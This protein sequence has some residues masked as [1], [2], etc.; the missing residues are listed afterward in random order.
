M[1]KVS[2]SK[3]KIE[4]KLAIIREAI[5]ELEKIGRKHT[6]E[7]FI[8]D[9]DKFA[10]AEHY[11]RRAL[12]AVFDIG[13]HIVSRYPYSPGKR[14]KSIKEI[15]TELGNRKIIDSK[16][17]EDKLVEMAGYRNRLVHFYDEI[18]PKELYQIITKDLG[19][20]EI[21]AQSVVRMVNKPEDLGLGLED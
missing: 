16:F 1:Y 20:L 14:P 8:N 3:T 18:T 12:E 11:L 4:T 9:R 13:G 19:D 5:V 7:Q 21:F 15:A 10:V 2:L 17:A 6:Q